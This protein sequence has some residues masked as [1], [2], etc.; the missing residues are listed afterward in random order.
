MTNKPLEHAKFLG[1]IQN[2]QVISIPQFCRHIIIAKE[3]DRPV[4][5]TMES[6]VVR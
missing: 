5:N 4:G 6:L 3:R 2:A 1:T